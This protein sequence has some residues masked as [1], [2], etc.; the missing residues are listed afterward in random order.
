[1][2]YDWMKMR[3]ILETCDLSKAYL[4]GSNWCWQH[5]SVRERPKGCEQ[6]LWVLQVLR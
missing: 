3:K 5:S 2:N 4:S 6:T 1:M